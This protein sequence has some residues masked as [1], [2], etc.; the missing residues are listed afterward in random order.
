MRKLMT[1]EVT[2]TLVKVAKMEM[3]DGQPKA[4]QMPDEILLGNV[5]LEKSQKAISK[6][7]GAGATVFE[8]IPETKVYEMAVEDFIK[9]ATLKVD[10]EPQSEQQT[11]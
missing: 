4:V 9:V 2:T 3:V 10:E 1:K 8:V 7:L 6:K 5:S 11:A